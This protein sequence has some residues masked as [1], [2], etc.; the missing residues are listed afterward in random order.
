MNITGNQDSSQEGTGQDTARSHGDQPKR[1][2]IPL[3]LD[4]EV[5]E[6][7]KSEIDVGAAIRNIV[8]PRLKEIFEREGIKPNRC[9]TFGSRHGG[10]G[11][12]SPDEQDIQ[13]VLA[14]ESIRILYRP[15]AEQGLGHWPYLVDIS[16][17]PEA[18]QGLGHWQKADE[19]LHYLVIYDLPPQKSVRSYTRARNRVKQKR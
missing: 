10:M 9:Y 16:H 15:E 4:D 6:H 19:I 5:L 17:R 1:R 8:S 12:I 13:E 2:V 7:L 3:C 18:E 14:D 11:H